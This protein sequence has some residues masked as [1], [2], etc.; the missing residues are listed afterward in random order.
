MP[1]GVPPADGSRSG[2]GK[3]GWCGNR[4]GTFDGIDQLPEARILRGVGQELLAVLGVLLHAAPAAG[5]CQ[6]SAASSLSAEWTSTASVITTIRAMAADAPDRPRQQSGLQPP[7]RECCEGG[8]HVVSVFSGESSIGWSRALD[9]S[10][11]FSPL[12]PAPPIPARPARARPTE[13]AA[14]AGQAR[15]SARRRAMSSA[16]AAA[17]FP[18]VGDGSARTTRGSPAD[19]SRPG[20]GHCST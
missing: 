7:R 14:G 15:G 5:P 9:S 6:V 2:V 13:S 3:P 11:H 18:A 16:S 4:I 1:P 20:S 17:S 10:R 12:A 19:R 8:R